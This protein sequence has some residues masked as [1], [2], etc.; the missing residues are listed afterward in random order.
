M[1]VVC[2]KI[3]M[4]NEIKILRK[5]LGFRQE[6]VA[7]QL[8]VTRQTIIAIEYYKGESLSLANVIIADSCKDPIALAAITS[9][10]C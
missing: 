5:E 8:G 1:K 4:R 6:D 7:T 3:A 10:R 9:P 2:L